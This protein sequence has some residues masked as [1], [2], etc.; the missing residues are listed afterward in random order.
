MPESISFKIHGMDCADEVALLKTEVGP[1]AGGE[2]NLSFNIIEGKMTVAITDEVVTTDAIRRAV[3]KTGMEAVP[4]LEFCDSELCPIEE[5]FWKQYGRTATCTAS[6]LLLFFGFLLHAY[7]H[8][9]IDALAAD[10]TD[11]HELPLFTAIF[12]LSAVVTGGWFI[13]PKAVFAA[14][15]FR[16]EMNLLMAIAVTGAIS[17]GEL[18]EAAAV[19]FLFSLALLLESWSVERARKAIK[20][21]VDLSPETARIVSMESGKLVE[22]GVNEVPVGSV[23][24]V[25]PGEKIP[26]DGLI[27]KGSTAVNQAP[28]TGESIPVNKTPGAEV[29]AGTING[30]GAFE[31]KST[32]AAKDTTLSRIIQLVEEAQS[33][34]APSEQWVEKFARYYTPAM[35]ALAVI[36][37]VIPPLIFGGAWVGWFYQALVILVIACPCA[38][39]ISTPVSIVAGLTAAA[40]AGVLIKGGVYLEIPAQLNGIALD[41]TG[42]LTYGRPAV[43]EVIPLNG[44]TKEQLLEYAAALEAHSTHPLARAVLNE[45]ESMGIDITPAEN[46]TVMPG[47]GATGKIDGKDYCIGSHRL[48]EEKGIEDDKTHKTAI[49]LESSGHSIVCIFSEKHVCGLISLADTIRDEAR[50][51]V[52]SLKT[53]GIS[54]VVMLTGDNQRTAE[55]VA[56]I[57]N[58]DSY[59]SELLPEEKV[60]EVAKLTEIFGKTAMVGDGV[61]DAPAMA[62]STMG[63]AMGAI[64][65]DAAI[66]TADIALMTDDLRKLPWLINHS[67]RTLSAIKQN[68]I[69]A[70][71]LKLVFIILALVG[72][73]TLWMAIAA[74]MGASLL[75]IFNGLRL[76]RWN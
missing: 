62:A 30:D 38:L 4:W 11:G 48:M 9:F 22:T 34:R 1:L 23:L 60:K 50:E 7:R 75:V 35:M 39:V 65:T 8:G 70:L 15:K 29:F 31:F 27:T 53:I 63:I 59:K 55:A 42:T 16:P 49:A 73:A 17:I 46:F 20:A 6:G 40:K 45:A 5:G 67:R 37:A 14:R 61:N 72:A 74:D 24:I 76:L 19:S 26:L 66:E 10:G 12:Y 56:N 33:H 13:A 58:V 52:Q 44:H 57:I 2:D 32:K 71:G 41:K 68:I 54:Q 28:I 25:R 47:K 43:Q 64:G 36:I 69:F 18:F 3:A 21:L 51:A